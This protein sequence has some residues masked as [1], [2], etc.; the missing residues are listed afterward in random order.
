[1][2][3]L[4]SAAKLLQNIQICKILVKKLKKITLFLVF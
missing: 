3:D 4:K 1:M 2:L